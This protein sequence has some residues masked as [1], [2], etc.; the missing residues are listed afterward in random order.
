MNSFLKKYLQSEYT[1]KDILFKGFK[2][3][4]WGDEKKKLAECEGEDVKLHGLYKMYISNSNYI[5][6]EEPVPT[7]TG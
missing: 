5:S 7:S 6:V 2:Y 1:A 3:A 4:T